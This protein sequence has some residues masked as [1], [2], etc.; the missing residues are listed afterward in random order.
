MK[1]TITKTT[2]NETKNFFGSLITKASLAFVLTSTLTLSA[3]AGPISD[4]GGNAVGTELFDFYENTDANV[5]SIKEI[6]SQNTTLS[7]NL[8]K[9]N[10]EYPGIVDMLIKDGVK[11]KKWIFDKKEI[12][13]NSDCKNA[14]L[15][16]TAEQKAVAC[17]NKFEVRIS[18]NWTKSTNETN[19]AGLILHELYLGYIMKQEPTM[20]VKTRDYLVRML[21]RATFE[22]DYQTIQNLFMDEL[23]KDLWNKKDQSDLIIIENSLKTYSLDY[24]SGKP[25]SADIGFN[26][27]VK[28]PKITKT[29][30][31]LESKIEL[32]SNKS[33]IT[34]SKYTK[35][36]AKYDSMNSTGLTQFKN[37]RIRL[38]IEDLI[39]KTELNPE[40]QGSTTR[41]TLSSVT[42]LVNMYAASLSEEDQ[43][44]ALRYFFDRINEINPALVEKTDFIN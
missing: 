17:Q 40:L 8:S 36:C 27:A 23:K 38:K 37:E 11:D 1:T 30:Y 35:F 21:N 19:V 7:L 15:V 14:T 10:V 5:V 26:T 29:H 34:R 43:Y 42:I 33:H 3:F 28:N 12:N 22:S 9:L 32:F 16:F 20:D 2:Q 13:F 6:I 41:I 24:C 39:S 4:G 44:K 31:E 25:V 18:K